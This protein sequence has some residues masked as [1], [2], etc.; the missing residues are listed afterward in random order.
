MFVFV[1]QFSLLIIN[2]YKID[3][4]KVIVVYDD[5]DTNPG[6]IRIRKKGGAGTHNGMKSVIYRL[7]SEEFPRIRVGIGMPEFKNDLIDYVI[8]NISDE[9]YELLTKGIKSAADAVE[10]VITDGIDIAMNKF[11]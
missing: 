7:G 9:E 11:N 2:F 1:D 4:E 10:S 5:I 3:L 8:G 6:E